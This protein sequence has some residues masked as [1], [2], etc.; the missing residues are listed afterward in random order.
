MAELQNRQRD[1]EALILQAAEK[2]FLKKG[3]SGAKTTSIAETAGV[4]HA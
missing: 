4:T 3:Y 2:E 1:T